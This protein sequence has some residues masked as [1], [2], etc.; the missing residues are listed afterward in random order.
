MTEFTFNPVTIR[1]S[2]QSET[3][4]IASLPHS[5]IFIPDTLK[6][7]YTETHLTRLRNTDWHLQEIYDFLP[8]LGVSVVQ[9]NFSRYVI[10]ANRGI[11]QLHGGRSYRSSLVY[12]KDTW[13]E[14][15]LKNPECDLMEDFR[16][17][18]FYEPFHQALQSVIEHKIDRFGY[19]YLLDMHSFAVETDADICLGAGKGGEKG[20][21]LKGRLQSVFE[22]SG[23]TTDYV[24]QFSGG[25]IIRHYGDMKS[26]EACM[27][28]LKYNT[29]MPDNSANGDHM[30]QLEPLR[31][32]I[33][34]HKLKEALTEVISASQNSEYCQKRSRRLAL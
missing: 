7:L 21:W 32:A 16:I 24:P 33:T 11:D 19:A 17:A 34:K 25:H 4:F 29:Y 13:G 22:R 20:P 26:V 3:P 5:G 18:N 27:I 10:D 9:A 1:P 15:I 8:D 31:A 28:E 6:K 2:T 23:F 12:T 30:P 14:P